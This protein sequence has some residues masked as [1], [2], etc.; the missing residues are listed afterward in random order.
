MSNKITKAAMHD[1]LGKTIKANS[2]KKLFDD[3]EKD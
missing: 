2:V 1:D 3:L